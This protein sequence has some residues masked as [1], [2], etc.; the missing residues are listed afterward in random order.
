VQRSVKL[1]PNTF[2]VAQVDALLSA[3]DFRRTNS[4]VAFR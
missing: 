3:G 4:C 1:P 2:V